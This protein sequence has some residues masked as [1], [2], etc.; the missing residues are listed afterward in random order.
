MPAKLANLPVA[1]IREN[2]VALRPVNKA[3]PDYI[4]VRDSVRMKGV[5]NAISVIEKNDPETDAVFYEVMDGLHRYTAAVDCGLE[6]IPCQIFKDVDQIGVLENQ[7]MANLVKVDTKPAQFAEA[8]KRMLA[9]QPSLT[10]AEVAERLAQS[11]AWLDARLSLTK[12]HPDIQALVDTGEIKVSNAIALA[13]LPAD[14]QVDFLEDAITKETAEFGSLCQDRVKAIAAAKREG[15]DPNA[16]PEFVPTAHLRKLSEITDERTGRKVGPS[17][18]VNYKTAVDGF[19]AAL[20]WVSSLDAA[21]LEAAKAKFDARQQA[22]A[23]KKAKAALAR[24]E[25]KAA[26][27]AAK[28]KELREKVNA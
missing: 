28:A 17:L 16:K 21:S 8:I 1:S 24:E 23:D 18:C 4:S 2:P 12:L 15:R 7:I 22:Q 14:E 9:L 20:E 11:T 19:Y 5:L 25:K 27:A 13:K 10:K 6:T 3:S 26:E